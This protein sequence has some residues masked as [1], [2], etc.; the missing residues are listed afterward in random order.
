VSAR[1]ALLCEHLLYWTG[2]VKW[3]LEMSKRLKCDIFVTKASDDN[4]M[5]FNQVGI[6]VKEFA[7]VSI[8][9]ARYWIFYPYFLWDNWCKLKRLLVEYDVI[10]STSPTTCF[11]GAFL[12][13]KSIFVMFE[14]NVWVYSPDFIKGLHPALRLIVK[15][16]HPIIK[17]LDRFAMRK[18]DKLVALD[19]FR[20]KQIEEIYGRHAE[21]VPVGVDT[22][23]FKPMPELI[24]TK[25]IFHV[26]TYLSPVK[27]THFI[28]ETLPQ[29]V[30]EVPDC[31]FWILN[32][33]EQQKERTDL[34]L[35][36][37]KLGVDSYVKFVDRMSEKSL[38]FYYSYAKVVVQPS[39]FTSHYWPILEGG[40]CETPAIAFDGIN[41]NEGVIDGVTGYLVPAGDVEALA[42]KIIEVLKNPNPE[43]GRKAREMVIQRFS[44]ERSAELMSELV[45]TC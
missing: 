3:M 9:D 40:A 12:K 23:L 36:A 37:R 21:V 6:E 13:K 28:I 17:W 14:P 20:A 39:S 10:I 44:W 29:I 25:M 2:G 27:G 19:G 8:N 16:G 31:Q 42:D 35:E 4:K 43:M 26:A 1:V 41:A 45:E 22:E 11:I 33:Q 5:L 7:D 38:P 18:A 24:D 15:A 34:M 30:K 32:A